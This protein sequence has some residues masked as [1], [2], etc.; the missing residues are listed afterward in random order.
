MTQ[1]CIYLL[2]IKQNIDIKQ[3]KNVYIFAFSGANSSFKGDSWYWDTF[4]MEEHIASGGFGVVVKARNKLD[5]KFYA[6]KKIP[7]IDTDI[8]KI[9][10]V[11]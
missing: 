9:L 10:Q 3:Y 6:I 5:K 8:K 4:S 11:Y 1:K 7:L 2:E